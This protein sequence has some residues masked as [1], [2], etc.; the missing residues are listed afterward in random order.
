[1]RRVLAITAFVGI[2]MHC[3]CGLDLYGERK[4]AEP[5]NF[6]RRAIESIFGEIRFIARSCTRPSLAG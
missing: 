2:S 6:E 5:E 3:G 1:M 4:C